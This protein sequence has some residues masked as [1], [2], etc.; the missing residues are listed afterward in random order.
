[1]T[2][3]FSVRLRAHR[4]LFRRSDQ[5]ILHLALA[6]LATNLSGGGMS[7]GSSGPDC[8]RASAAVDGVAVARAFAACL[9]DF[10][11]SKRFDR[12]LLQRICREVRRHQARF[13]QL[14]LLQRF[15]SLRA[16][17]HSHVAVSQT[18]DTSPNDPKAKT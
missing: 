18:P 16:Q 11:R 12:L 17:S 5:M 2:W 15:Q 6:S 13:I 10:R 9:L 3:R 14:Y 1:M 7:S 8:G 4:S